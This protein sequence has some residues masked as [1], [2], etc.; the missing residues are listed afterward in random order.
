MYAFIKGTLVETKQHHVIV[1]N[2]GIGYL[3]SVPSDVM[4]KLPQIGQHVFL[5]LSYVVRELSHA[6]YGF[7]STQDRDLFEALMDV[8]GIGPKSAI[9][10]VGHMPAIELLNAIK[11]SQIQVLTK[12]PGIGK[13]TAE[14]MIIE[15]RDKIESLVPHSPSDY[16]INLSL[17]PRS[18]MISDAMSALI[19]LGC[20]QLSAQKVIKKTLQDTPEGLTLEVLITS[21]LKQLQKN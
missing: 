21:S 5:H 8:S 1:E 14:R 13:K 16:A 9:A 19:N 20:T 10:I 4:G 3:V 17:D 15:L 6:L 12:V 2:S 11:N 18:Q 7:L